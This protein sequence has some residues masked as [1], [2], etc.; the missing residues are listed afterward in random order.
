MAAASGSEI[1][2]NLLLE[3][4]ADPLAV[5]E[6]GTSALTLLVTGILM[7]RMPL[8]AIDILLKAGAD[9]DESADSGPTEGYTC[10]MMAARNERPDLV[11]YLAERKADI[12]ARAADGSTALSLAV[13]EEDQEMVAL[14]TELGAE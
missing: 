9:I 10:L 5:Q 14:L 13:K 8:D 2:F 6:N 11:R 7:E 4:G 3:K 1:L 12:N